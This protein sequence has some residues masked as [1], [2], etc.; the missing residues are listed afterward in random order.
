MADKIYC[1]IISATLTSLIILN[2]YIITQDATGVAVAYTFVICILAV[3][4]VREIRKE[5]D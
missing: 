4:L 3:W 5:D 2:S 1:S